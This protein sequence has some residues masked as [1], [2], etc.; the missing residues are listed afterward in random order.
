MEECHYTVHLNSYYTIGPVLT[1]LIS[2][3]YCVVAV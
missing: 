2:A 1:H 3:D